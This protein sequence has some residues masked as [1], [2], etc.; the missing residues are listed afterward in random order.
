[1]DVPSNSAIDSPLLLGGVL[2]GIGWG[3]AGLCPGLA[4]MAASSGS[5][6]AVVFV[7]AMLLGMAGHG[8]FIQK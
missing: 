6:A 1:M 7:V 8:K 2:F 4:L 3:V 5:V